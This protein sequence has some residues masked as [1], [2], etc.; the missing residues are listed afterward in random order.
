MRGRG[1]AACS[2]SGAGI[3]GS[4]VSPLARH[5]ESFLQDEARAEDF[6]AEPGGTARPGIAFK[7]IRSWSGGIL[8]TSRLPFD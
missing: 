1:R 5:G 7:D 2:H 8:L 3:L 6:A 4:R